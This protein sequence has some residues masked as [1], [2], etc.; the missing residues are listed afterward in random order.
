MQCGI[1]ANANA[2]QVRCGD[3]LALNRRVPVSIYE[4]AIIPT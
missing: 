1:N 3:M 2:L 4:A